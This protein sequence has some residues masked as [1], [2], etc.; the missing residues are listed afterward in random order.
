MSDRQ[1]TPVEIRRE[2]IRALVERLGADGAI[3]FLQQYEPGHGDYTVDRD[4]WLKD[5]TVDEICERIGRRERGAAPP[6]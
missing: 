4:A 2:G 1:L 6:K 3:R 5:E